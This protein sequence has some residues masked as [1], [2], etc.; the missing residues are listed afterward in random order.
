YG[1]CDRESKCGYHLNPY[2]DGYAKNLWLEENGTHSN[3]KPTHIPK[4]TPKPKPT[5]PTVFFPFEI[6]KQT[7]SGYEKNVFIQNLLSNVP[8]PFDVA[9]VEKIISLYRLGTVQNGYRSGAITFPFIDV[10]QNIRTIQVKQ[11]DQTNHTTGTDFL[12][13]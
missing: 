10:N 7:L 9:D 2:S 6:F 1:R 13:S 5:P 11:F 12:H 8:F 3:W 4:Y